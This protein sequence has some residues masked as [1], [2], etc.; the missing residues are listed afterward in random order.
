MRTIDGGVPHALWMF[1]PAID[2]QSNGKKRG[3]G[4]ALFIR[5]LS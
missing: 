3:Q 4:T 5:A 2:T 1:H